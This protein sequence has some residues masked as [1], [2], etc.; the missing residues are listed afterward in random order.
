MTTS[1]TFSI[2][3][4][5]ARK[6]FGASRA[7]RAFLA[8]VVLA[9]APAIWA[10]EAYTPS[11]Q[12]LGKAS[13][14]VRI[15][16]VFTGEF[17]DGAPVYRLPSITVSANR[18]AELAKIAREEQNARTSNTRIIAFECRASSASA[19]KPTQLPLWC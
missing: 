4:G 10:V 18:K 6:L 14:D 5:I 9:A 16:G 7:V 2:N 3:R 1:F 19:G 11:V 8:L 13:T 17:A 12:A 15:I